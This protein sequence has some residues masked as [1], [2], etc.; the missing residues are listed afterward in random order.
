ME[1]QSSWVVDNLQEPMAPG[2]DGLPDTFPWQ[3][4]MRGV[5]ATPLFCALVP[6][7]RGAIFTGPVGNGRHTQAKALAYSLLERSLEIPGNFENAC[8]ILI[9]PGVV[10]PALEESMLIERVDELYETVNKLLQDAVENVSIIFDQIDQ[11]PQ[12]F[13]DRV[14]AHL[15]C[16]TSEKLF[17]ICVGG[18]ESKISRNLQR[19]LPHCRCLLPSPQERRKY[20]QQIEL[21]HVK[22]TWTDPFN[23]AEIKIAVQ[24]EG[25]TMEEIVEK[26]EGYSYAD[27]EDLL[28]LIKLGM[29]NCDASEF[30]QTDNVVIHVLR[31]DVLEAINLS[32]YVAEQERA[33]QL[34][35]LQQPLFQGYLNGSESVHQNAPAKHKDDD[36]ELSVD[37]K[38]DIIERT[39]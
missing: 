11:Y 32:R 35:T 29:S 19:Q 5:N 31:E 22:D 23:P 20:L 37:A 26:T 3:R 18:C 4:F 2:I 14:A 17:T 12:C 25:I 21:I 38:L 15:L 39:R 9:D 10:S 7:M 33:E 36:E 34:V 30:K 24:F 16:Q 8:L 27:L 28:W 1:T 6:V 13:M